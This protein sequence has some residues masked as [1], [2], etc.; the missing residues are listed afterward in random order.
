ML[1]VMRHCYSKPCSSPVNLGKEH[2][3]VTKSNLS[4]AF[5]SK[6]SQTYCKTKTMDFM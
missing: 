3:F 5:D 2:I 6:S 1:S 4:L